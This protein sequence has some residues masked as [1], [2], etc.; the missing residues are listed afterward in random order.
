MRHPIPTLISILVI[1]L[2]PLLVVADPSFELDPVIN[3]CV[4]WFSQSVVKNDVLYIDGGIQ[5]YNGTQQV[6]PI[7]GINNYLLAIPLNFT[8]DWKKNIKINA[9]PKNETNPRTG[10]APPSLIRGHMFHG[11]DNTSDVFLFGGT[12]YQGNTSFQGYSSPDAS[13]Y[14]L[15]SYAYGS[16][17]F[18][19]DQY[20]ISQPWRVNHGAAAEAIDHGLGFYLNGQIDWGTS[21]RTGTINNVESYLPVDGMLVINLVTQT[22]ANITTPGLR[23]NAA[24]VG[25]SM[26]YITPVG[27]EGILVAIGG[28]INQD[29]PYADEK[30]GQ[31][32]DLETVDIFDI[33]SYFSNSSSNGTWYEQKT[34]GQIPP[35]RTDFCTVF[36]SA[37]DNSS[38]NIYLY[39]GHDPRE[40]DTAYDD[41]YV[42]SMPSFIW[43]AVFLDGATPR[44]GHNCH[45]VN[46]RQLVTVGGNVTNLPCD[47]EAKGVA[48]LDMTTITWG[49]VFLT[50]TTAYEVPLEIYSKIG[51]TGK[52][53]ATAK[54]PVLGWN[55][56]G[57]KKVFDTPRRVPSPP[58][59]PSPSPTPK[60]SK[61]NHAGAIA[62]GVVG[63][64]AALALLAGLLFFLRRRRAQANEPAELAN[65]GEVA[66]VE[67][68][69]PSDEKKA[70]LHAGKEGE[71]HELPSPDPVEL[72][73]PREFAEA[74]RDTATGDLAEL[75]GTNISPGASP[76]IP[77]VRTPGDEDLV[78][79]PLS[80]GLSLPTEAER[81]AAEAEREAAEAER[82]AAEAEREA[83]EAE[84]E[85]AEAEREA[86]REAAASEERPH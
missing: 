63:G 45:R 22:S 21:T 38:H 65:D 20:D 61:S 19:W 8:W 32:L 78:P 43:T 28:Q 11:P 71:A 60:P 35:P 52:G 85:A 41:L 75:P 31:L 34:T 50:N 3:F 66:P 40:N 73:A 29:R 7:W 30:K 14:P 58:S 1:L 64:I 44:W 67:I 26:D 70:E 15:W 17:E 42:L 76:G 72:D 25:G 12:T 9:S 56:V 37:P 59:T 16:K 18:P 79:P 84:R 27:A 4:R 83:A 80:R 55:T 51:G 74:P 36:A 39:G 68:A 5:K 82:E 10:T 69:R 53:N 33:D 81:E 24:R 6:T 77:I 48:F 54:E 13:T 86:E 2:H 57:L 47:W 62:G 49:S 46:N 23:G